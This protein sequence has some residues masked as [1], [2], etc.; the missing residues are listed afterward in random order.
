MIKDA[1]RSAIVLWM[2]SVALGAEAAYAD[3]ILGTEPAKPQTPPSSIQ[4]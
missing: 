2:L 4:A 3:K 1:R